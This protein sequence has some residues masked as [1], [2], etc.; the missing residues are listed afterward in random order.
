LSETARVLIIDDEPSV[1]DALRLIL[2]DGGYGVVVAPTGAQGIRQARERAF[3][4]IITDLRLPDMTG[5]DVLDALCRHNPQSLVVLIT[6]HGTPELFA[7]ARRCGAVG[8]L[9]K[10]FQPSEILQ[11]IKDTLASRKPTAASFS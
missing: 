8:G 4:L 10:P 5:L 7:E 3:D 1:R 11:L 9:P 6:S 2:E